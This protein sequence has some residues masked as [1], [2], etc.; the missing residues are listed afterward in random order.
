MAFKHGK[1]T[2]VHINASDLSSYFNSSSAST[3]VAVAET[4]T[5]GV[6]GSAKT[7]VAGHNDAT[8]SLGGLFD[9]DAGA[10]DEVISNVLGS[11]NDINFTIIES[12]A[13]Q[14]TVLAPSSAQVGQRCIIGQAISTKYSVDSPVGGV[15]S[16]AVDLQ[17]DGGTDHGVI[18]LYD[19]SA[20]T[21]SQTSTDNAA[22]TSNG[23]IAMLH[24]F[25][26]TYGG[27]MTYRVQHSV[28][29]SS[30]VD[31]VTFT[32]VGSS[33]TTSQRVVVAAGA[34]VNR[35][36]RGSVTASGSGGYQGTLLSFAR[37]F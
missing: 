36:L 15:V 21:A 20:L 12:G 31:L 17:V 4:T 18:L 32:A 25:T 7:Y 26:N 1:N 19:Q 5:Y 8:V 16:V 27:T 3:S 23:G 11:S 14:S 34:N 28:D 6:A 2:K 30:W 13:R 33:T 10:V 24:V 37:R 9:G 29:N 22:A 35:Y